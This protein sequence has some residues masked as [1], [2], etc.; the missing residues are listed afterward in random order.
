MRLKLDINEQSIH[1]FGI[2][3]ENQLGLGGSIS[4][5]SIEDDAN[6]YHFRFTIET[7]GGWHFVLDK[8]PNNG[9]WYRL[10]CSTR[11]LDLRIEF[12]KDLK[13]FCQQIARIKQMQTDYVNS[14]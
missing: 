9:A 12:I 11:E 13:L 4:K 1:K 2:L 10:H 14:K 6:Q 5:V 3:M 7:F 8:N